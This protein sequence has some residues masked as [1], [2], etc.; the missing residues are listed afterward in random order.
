[1]VTQWGQF[2]DHDITLTPG[3]DDEDD[4]DSHNDDDDDNNITL[5]PENE[6]HDCCHEPDQ[7]EC[8]PLTLPAD[9]PFYSSLST[10]QTCLEFTRSTAF[11]EDPTTTREQMNAIT[12]YVDASNVYGSDEVTGA[13]LRTYS[14]GKLVVGGD[15]EKE[16]LPEIDGMMQ[17]REM[18]RP[19]QQENKI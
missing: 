16:L 18:P 4:D 5:T 14:G 3:D 10:A 9:D 12:A 8:F 1:M 6:V 15:S 17:V 19:I 7:P 2:L 13:L 11:C